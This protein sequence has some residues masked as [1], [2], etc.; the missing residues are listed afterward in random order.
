VDE[1]MF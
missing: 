1:E